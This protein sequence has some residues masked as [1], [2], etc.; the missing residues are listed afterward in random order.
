MTLSLTG[1]AGKTG[2]TDTTDRPIL[3]SMVGMTGKGDGPKP[4]LY[5]EVPIVVRE[6]TS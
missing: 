6:T 3:T 2:M 4:R 1:M 5:K